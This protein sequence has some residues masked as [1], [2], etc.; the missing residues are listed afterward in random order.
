MSKPDGGP[1]FACPAI[2][3]SGHF[4]A[5][6]EPG[7]SKRFYAA[8]AAMQ[9]DWASQ[10]AETGEFTASIT[11]EQLRANAARY[12]RMADAMIAEEQK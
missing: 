11:D 1:A 6:T 5:P 3:D 10:S 4:V 9:G 2:P 12:F 7:M 8:C